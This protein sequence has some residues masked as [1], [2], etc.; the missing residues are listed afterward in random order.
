MKCYKVVL[1]QITH[2]SNSILY[3]NNNS[4]T[5]KKTQK[6]NN[7]P[8]QTLDIV[9]VLLCMLYDVH[10]PIP[11]LCMRAVVC[12]SFLSLS[13]YIYSK[14]KKLSV[15]MCVQQHNVISNNDTITLF[16]T[17]IFPYHFLAHIAHTLMRFFIF[18]N[19]S[20][21]NHILSQYCVNQVISFSSNWTGSGTNNSTDSQVAFRLT[22]SRL[23][24][25]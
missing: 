8:M 7:T 9:L 18:S 6:N 22:R 17:Y 21:N 1:S 4:N 12:G 3:N 23:W 10:S 20:T 19:E 11:K 15:N 13:L 5:Q 25:I 14:T 2:H 24:P 16:C